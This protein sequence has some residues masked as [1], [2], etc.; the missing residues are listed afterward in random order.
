MSKNKIMVVLLI[1]LS[2][3][4]ISLYTTFGYEGDNNV[5]EEES[6]SDH[7]ITTSLKESTDKEIFV[8][9]NEEKFIDISLKN[10][11]DANIRYG[12]YYYMI[13]PEKLPDDVT[14]TL[15]DDSIDPLENII[16]SGETKSVSIRITNNSEYTIN[17][18]VGA[19]GGFEKGKIEDIELDGGI[20]IK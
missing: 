19:V 8:N 12:M 10:T 18:I 5:I 7:K 3:G 13:N 4:I 14:I 20:L 15:A 11:Y 17:L 2:I 6:T 1:M 16:K 9:A